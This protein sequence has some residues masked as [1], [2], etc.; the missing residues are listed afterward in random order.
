[1]TVKITTDPLTTVADIFNNLYPA[2]DVKAEFVFQ[3]DKGHSAHGITVFERDKIPIIKIALDA[4]VGLLVS[5]LIHELAHVAEYYMQNKKL[6]QKEED[7]HS[8]N[9]YDI[10]YGIAKVYYEKIGLEFELIEEYLRTE[11]LDQ[12]IGYC[13]EK[14]K[15]MSVVV[16]TDRNLDAFKVLQKKIS[17]YVP[18]GQK[19]IL[20]EGIFDSGKVDLVSVDI[21]EI[22]GIS[23]EEVDI[24]LITNEAQK[25][26]SQKLFSAISLTFKGKIIVEGLNNTAEFLIS[27]NEQYQEVS[28]LLNSY[29]ENFKANI[30]FD[31]GAKQIVFQ[32]TK[33]TKMENNI[34]VKNMSQKCAFHYCENNHNRNIFRLDMHDL[35]ICNEHIGKLDIEHR[36]MNCEVNGCKN[37]VSYFYEY[38]KQIYGLCSEHSQKKHICQ[39][40]SCNEDPKG[41]V[42][43]ENNIVFACSNH[44]SMYGHIE[45]LKLYPKEV[46]KRFIYHENEVIVL[47]NKTCS[48]YQENIAGKNEVDYKEK[49]NK[50]KDI[51]N[52]ILQYID[53]TARI[54]KIDRPDP[55]Y[56]IIQFVDHIKKMMIL[57]YD[58]EFKL[59]QDKRQL[60]LAYNELK[61]VASNSQTF[62]NAREYSEEFDQMYLF[63]NDLTKKM[64]ILTKNNRPNTSCKNNESLYF[65]SIQT[66]KKEGKPIIIRIF[67]N[68]RCIVE[69]TESCIAFENE[70]ILPLKVKSIIKMERVTPNIDASIEINYYIDREENER[71]FMLYFSANQ[72]KEMCLL[73]DMLGE[74]YE[75]YVFTRIH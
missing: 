6:P 38:D 23:F 30:L 28:L 20:M 49:H 57:L 65:K 19:V 12:H 18:K 40:S 73:Y 4:P 67:G 37:N 21:V 53:D 50:T 48:K 2:F 47:S 42:K 26:W 69:F 35:F 54:Y 5:I 13:L 62:C 34:G 11:Q 36:E 63:L 52:D 46:D 29:N 22:N 3:I 59:N 66:E 56:S 45:Y 75:D 58:K 71:S 55:D 16:L 44:Y 32:K 61:A 41:L 25:A 39:F 64:Q 72:N 1:M 68:N 9:F 17:R 15:K 74:L 27:K 70:I 43:V 33:E 7:I 14:E 60:L 8:K 31:R 51:F 24:L 10:F